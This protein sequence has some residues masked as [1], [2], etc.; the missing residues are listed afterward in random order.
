MNAIFLKSIF[1]LLM[2]IVMLISFF[3]VIMTLVVKSKEYRD[4][5]STW[6]FP[7]LLAIFLEVY[8]I[9]SI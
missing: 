3:I 2:F 7:M 8:L 9:D 5:F 6:Q 1:K 4:V